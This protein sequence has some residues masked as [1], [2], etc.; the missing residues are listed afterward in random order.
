MLVCAASLVIGCGRETNGSST[1]GPRWQ[2]AAFSY[3]PEQFKVSITFLRYDHSSGLN[4]EPIKSRPR[5]ALS[6][7]EVLDT[8]GEEGWHLA[9]REGT[10]YL[11]ERPRSNWAWE[12]FTIEA[13]PSK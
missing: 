7:A 6:L 8:L 9:S 10:E 13:D 3:R 11:M 5:Q 1:A 12:S 4:L 2:V